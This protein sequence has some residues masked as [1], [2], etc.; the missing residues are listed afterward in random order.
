MNEQAD[1][2]KD[3]NRL[4]FGVRRSV[5]YHSRRRQH[6]ERL[7][8]AVLFLALVLGSVTVAT[9]AAAIGA[10]WPLWLKSLPAATVSLLAGLDLVVGS[11]RQAWLHAD[12]ARQFIDLER[13]LARGQTDLTPTLIEEVTAARLTIEATEPP[14]LRVLD[15]LC[16]N[17]LLRAMG[18]DPARE[19]R[20]GFFQRLFAPFFDLAEQ[21]L[22][23]AAR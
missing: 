4:L 12:L 7:H 15:T 14:V 11:T 22:H 21:R 2:E 3:Y 17:E 13:R 23:S 16:H 19:V 10:D 5:R 20:V 1:L 9:F 8:N 6:Y 18:Y